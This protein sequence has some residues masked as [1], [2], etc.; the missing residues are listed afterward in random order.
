M[1]V[2]ISTTW[3][4]SMTGGLQTKG[5]DSWCTHWSVAWIGMT[6]VD[7]KRFLAEYE[8]EITK[9]NWFRY[10]SHESPCTLSWRSVFFYPTV[11]RCWQIQQERSWKCAWTFSSSW[12][13][14]LGW[15]SNCTL[16]SRWNVCFS[17]WRNKCLIQVWVLMPSDISSC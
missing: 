7:C 10:S 2:G 13:R 16:I 12:R 1:F 8:D 3:M 5:I 4:A 17:P 14:L 9:S 11:C 15:H 6:L